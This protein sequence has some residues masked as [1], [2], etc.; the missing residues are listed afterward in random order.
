MALTRYSCIAHIA[1]PLH[2]S[3]LLGSLLEWVL[4]SRDRRDARSHS[5]RNVRTRCTMS[6]RHEGHEC[7][8]SAQPA[9]QT[10]WPQGTK[11]TWILA[12]MHT[13]HSRVRRR[14]SSSSRRCACMDWG[15]ELRMT[16]AALAM[17]GGWELRV[18]GSPC[19]PRAPQAPA[20]AAPS[21][22]PW[23]TARAPSSAALAAR[24]PVPVVCT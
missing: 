11:T 2:R 23:R 22:Q 13:T 7:T 14:R 5:S 19:R 8:C 1:I 6:A 18:R 4:S 16:R 9:Q 21:A 24:A 3:Q 17:E 10:M 20:A 15:A 12:S